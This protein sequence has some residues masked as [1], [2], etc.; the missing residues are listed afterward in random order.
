MIRG[1]RGNALCSKAERR[2]CHTLNLGN[3]TATTNEAESP[4]ATKETTH[5]ARLWA[6]PRLS[7]SKKLLEIAMKAWR[8]PAWL[9]IPVDSLPPDVGSL[10]YLDRLQVHQFYWK[11]GEPAF[12]C[13][14]FCMDIYDPSWEKNHARSKIIA[15]LD[16]YPHRVS[17]ILAF[18]G[19]RQSYHMYA[20]K[21][22]C[23]YSSHTIARCFPLLE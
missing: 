14:R 22:D 8:I 17:P 1:L 13:K 11:L 9:N 7:K 16:V 12:V 21:Y 18:S 3:A 10:F 15:S 23:I 4:K 6:M 20:H 5:Q 19:V 2:F